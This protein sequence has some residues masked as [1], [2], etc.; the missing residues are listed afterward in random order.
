MIKE[1]L[2]EIKEEIYELEETLYHYDDHGMAD[3]PYC[4][5]VSDELGDLYDEEEKLEKKVEELEKLK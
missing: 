5:E 4:E 3:D 1:R 2:K